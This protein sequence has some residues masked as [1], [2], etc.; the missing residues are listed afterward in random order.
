MHGILPEMGAPRYRT[1]DG[2]AG[3]H[4]L[5][6]FRLS[7]C[8]VRL[9]G[10]AERARP[11]PLEDSA[12]GADRHVRPAPVSLP[13]RGGGSRLTM[14]ERKR[15]LAA[16]RQTAQPGADRLLIA[17]GFRALEAGDPGAAANAFDRLQVAEATDAEALNAAAVLGLKLGRDRHAAELL[18]RA[19][20]IDG[21]NAAYRC[22]RAIACRRLGDVDAAIAELEAARGL[23]PRLPEVHANLGNALL[24]R[25]DR[26]GAR[27]SFE[28]ALRL[29]P[30]FVEALNGLG[31]AELAQGDH[32]RARGRFERALAL[33]PSFHEA[34]YNLSRA[35]MLAAA[36]VPAS[37][38][39]A[40][41]AQALACI[42]AALQVSAGNAAYWTQFEAAVARLDLVHPVDASLR[43]TLLQALAHPAVDAARL[44]RPIVS[45][46]VTQPAWAPVAQWVACAADDG[47]AAVPAPITELR[48]VLG[49]PLLQRLLED[50]VVASAPVQQLV[51]V[52]RRSLLRQWAAAHA[53][54]PSLPLPAIGA[55]ALQGFNTEYVNAEDADER[56]ALA[57]LTGA[58]AAARAA[59]DAVPPHWYAILGCY[60]PLGVLDAPDEIVAVLSAASLPTLAARQIVEPREELRLRATIPALTAIADA[61]ST[62]V[63]DQYEANPYPRWLRTRRDLAPTTPDRHLRRMFPDARLGAVADGPARILVA[64]CG[65]GLHPIGTALRFRTS[66]VLAVDLSRTSLAYAQ[67]KTR[68]LGIDNIEYRQA[69]VLALGSLVDRFD[70][71]E[72]TGVLHHLQDP[73]AG[74][75]V[76]CGLLRP[77]G[78]M[79]IGLYSETARRHV[80]RAREL[81]AAAGLAA[82]PD[83]IRACRQAILARQDDPLLLR[84]TRGEDFYSLSGCRDL[85]FHV[86]EHRFTLPQIAVLLADLGLT[87][88]GFELP[89]AAVAASY[90]SAHPDDRGQVDLDR[91]HRFEQANPDTFARMYQFW[92]HKPGPDAG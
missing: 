18:A 46:V 91:W 76:L 81:V 26:D 2:T 33:E 68:E 3:R 20:A 29:R 51:A 90:R 59:G 35:Q 92:V 21:R 36:S 45:L 79:R 82:T 54:E 17:Q 16:G 42:L 77:G 4:A 31:D 37:E 74:A 13:P 71:I 62:A 65:T 75:R 40:P 86:Q 12:D 11:T 89:D 67:R 44:V 6:C 9:E 27:A 73:V 10:A 30:D 52:A 22:H 84:V 66:A 34:L 88:L 47:A 41:A 87:F 23:D 57:A 64:G 28:Q 15:R 53:S 19:I 63:R 70:V 32:A 69:D 60:R 72:C 14:G 78:C 39:A 58:I 7:R 83:G 61:V 5:L 55:L 43:A 1:R 56:A 48:T 85:L 50:V 80:V 24:E 38:A 49:D 8:L 25:G